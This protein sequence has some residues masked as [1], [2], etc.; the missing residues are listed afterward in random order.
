[1]RISSPERSLGG[2]IKEGKE[3][4]FLNDMENFLILDKAL[5]T[6][7]NF[8]LSMQRK[9]RLIQRLLE[10][11]EQQK[12]IKNRKG[13]SLENQGALAFN[14]FPY[15]ELVAEEDVFKLCSIVDF[16]YMGNYGGNSNFEW[17][18]VPRALELIA[19]Y[20]GDNAHVTGTIAFNHPLLYRRK[21]GTDVY[22]LCHREDERYAKAT[23]LNLAEEGP[24][25]LW[26]LAEELPEPNL[27]EPCFLRE[28]LQGN[29][30]HKQFKNRLKGWL[31]LDNGFF[32]SVDPDMYK[33]TVQWFEQNWFK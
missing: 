6:I 19:D 23:I 30:D 18:E 4:G 20:V 27:K 5:K 3:G 16:D 11:R 13:L 25:R 22:Y 29:T 10:P 8:L 2:I 17:G 9:T 31:E 15:H 21:A 24:K 28:V 1:M 26:Q 32:F 14:H 12:N 33:K 7:Q